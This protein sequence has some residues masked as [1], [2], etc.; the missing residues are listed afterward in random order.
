MNE[1]TDNQLTSSMGKSDPLSIFSS[2]EA[3]SKIGEI[4]ARHGIV[5][6]NENRDD[7]P[8]TNNFSGKVGE[9]NDIS[10]NISAS[11]PTLEN[12]ENL[13]ILQKL[14]TIMSLFSALGTENSILDKQQNDL[15]RAI[16]PYLSPRRKDV[17]DN[18]LKFER[19]GAT[20]KKLTQGE[21]NVSQ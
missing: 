16:R 2:P 15:L 7:A 17:L 8:P 10:E 4:L 13:D 3:L 6:D 21:K 18:L 12:F 19:I 1:G 5:S 14:P 20:I 9:N 11:A